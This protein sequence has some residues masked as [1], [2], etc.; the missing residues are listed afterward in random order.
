MPLTLIRKTIKNIDGANTFN[1]TPGGSIFQKPNTSGGPDNGPVY[2]TA[3][4]FDAKLSWIFPTEEYEDLFGSNISGPSGALNTFTCEVDKRIQGPRPIDQVAWLDLFAPSSSQ[5]YYPGFLT[6][7]WVGKFL[8]CWTKWTIEFSQEDAMAPDDSGTI[9]PYKNLPYS[10]DDYPYF[11]NSVM[12]QKPIWTE[13]EALYKHSAVKG[14]DVFVPKFFG[15]KPRP[16]SVDIGGVAER[17]QSGSNMEPLNL[18][19]PE[20]LP[21]VGLRMDLEGPEIDTLFSGA[22]EQGFLGENPKTQDFGASTQPPQFF[23]CRRYL[24]VN[25]KRRSFLY[26]EEAPFV[27]GDWWHNMSFPRYLK[28]KGKS[29]P[30][31]NSYEARTSTEDNSTPTKTDIGGGTCLIGPCSF[32]IKGEVYGN[33]NLVGPILATQ[34]ANLIIRG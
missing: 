17:T 19:G 22:R 13:D 25:W 21:D 14:K 2:G 20:P 4:V 30:N 31:D 10:I 11:K 28:R 3:P 1:L 18:L 33:A 9:K 6:L 24:M 26:D 5:H 27:T 12:S 32:R 15:Q 8:N 34:Y 7:K 23:D 29:L 16:F